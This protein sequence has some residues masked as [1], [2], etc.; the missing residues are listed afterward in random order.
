V[1]F[2]H[3]YIASLLL[4]L[5]CITFVPVNF[6][7]H[8]AEDEHAAAMHN[9]QLAEQHHCE[10]DDYYCDASTQTQHCD[11]PQHIAKTTANCFSCEFH[12][13][14][15]FQTNTNQYGVETPVKF[16]QYTQHT[17]TLLRK[18]I[19][20]LSNKGPPTQFGILS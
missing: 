9:H 18:A 12:F 4:V 17:P 20:L 7:H 15:H 13:I 2:I 5:F 11:H 8:H 14:K 16:T 10:L 1:K 6:L 19:I 3:R